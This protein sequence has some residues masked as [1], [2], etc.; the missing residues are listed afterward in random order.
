MYCNDLFS[1]TIIECKK[2]YGNNNEDE[3]LSSKIK[4][5]KKPLVSIN[6]TDTENNLN[7]CM[8]S[9]FDSTDDML[10][11]KLL[12]GTICSRC[13]NI[14][15]QQPIEHRK[16]LVS[17]KML[18]ANDII[19]NR[20]DSHYLSTTSGIGA[21][22]NRKPDP[23]TPES[24]ESHSP[25]PEFFEKEINLFNDAISDDELIK[26]HQSKSTGV[27][28]RQLKSRLEILKNES[29]NSD[30]DKGRKKSKLKSNNCC[31]YYCVIL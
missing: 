2:L 21:E 17:K 13:C 20:I 22:G 8:C 6:L 10:S 18:L 12:D 1:K 28:P 15:K 11:M 16:M 5:F 23:Y 19:V 26:L 24:V 7:V 14:I 3:K 30:V 31:P 25:Q 27:S 4:L 29:Q 9:V